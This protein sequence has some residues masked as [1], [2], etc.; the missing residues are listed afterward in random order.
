L[1]RYVFLDNAA[2]TPPLLAVQKGVNEFLDWYSSIHRGSGFK[3]QLSTEAYE[4]SKHL[5]VEFLGGDSEERVVIYGKN[6]TEAVNKLANR[7]PFEE[8]QVL[9]TSQ[10]EHH[11]NDLPWRSKVKIERFGFAPDGRVDLDELENRLTKK[12]VA[13]LAV[14]GASNVT[15][16]INPIWDMARL[17][18][19]YGAEIVVD[20]AQLAPHRQLNIGIR[21][22]EDAI[23]YVVL[24][25]HKMYAPFGTG[26]LIGWKDVFEQGDPDVTGG[27][28]VKIVT[29]EVVYWREP[30]EKEEAG[31]PNVVGAVALGFA[32]RALSGIGMDKV[33]AHEA[34]LTQRLLDGLAAI[35]GVEVYGM[36]SSDVDARVGVVPFNLRRHY[37]AKVAAI[38]GYE[39]GIGIRSGCF[40]AHTY[41]KRLMNL[42]EEETRILIDKIRKNERVDL[43]GLAR[44]SFGVYNDESDVDAALNAIDAIANDRYSGNYILDPVTGEYKPAGFDLDLKHMFSFEP[45]FH[46]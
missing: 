2:S 11:S 1:A 23:D 9:L 39:F 18:H 22:E 28:T 15:G 29:E 37:H 36:Q 20:A 45:P 14:T 13:L 8:G 17:A 44:F 3:S 41:L 6:T 21:G 12:N 24:S 31:S 16:T 33:A 34:G 19:R 27:G 7:Y 25:G 5:L 42:D 46:S 4:K 35:P 32:V 38:L 40:C 30:P 43:P 26:A 10:M